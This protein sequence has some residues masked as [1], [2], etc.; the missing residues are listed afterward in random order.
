MIYLTQP[1]VPKLNILIDLCKYYGGTEYLSGSGAR[2]YLDT[3]K[4][5]NIKVKFLVNT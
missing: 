4:F 5:Q 3:D 2:I 1:L